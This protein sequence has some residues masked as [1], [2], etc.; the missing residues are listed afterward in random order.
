[1]RLPGGVDQREIFIDT[2]VIL[3]LFDASDPVQTE[4]S[5]KL[6]DDAKAGVLRLVVGPP[7]LFE[8]AWVLH[9]ACGRRNEEVLDVIEALANWSGLSVLDGELVLSAIS[10]AR[11]AG[12]GFADSYIAVTAKKRGL[13]VVTYNT[14]HFS[15]FD[16][17]LHAS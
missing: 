7:V 6:F 3:R 15:K 9:S 17:D 13:K 11:S 16:I 2:N 10:L 5:K 8:L 12:Q 1:M 14:R 4:R